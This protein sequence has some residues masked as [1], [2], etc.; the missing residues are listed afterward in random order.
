MSGAAVM[1]RHLLVFA[2]VLVISYGTAWAY[3]TPIMP[4]HKDYTPIYNNGFCGGSY[5]GACHD[6]NASTFLPETL[7]HV[8]NVDNKKDWTNFCLS[9][10]NVSGEAHER[11][12]GTPSTNTYSLGNRTTLVPGS[13]SGRSHSWNGVIG[14]AGTTF[15][16]NSGFEGTK[17]RVNCQVCHQGMSKRREQDL[18]WKSTTTSDQINYTINSYASTKQYLAKYIRVYRASTATSRPNNSRTK[19]NYLVDPSEYSYNPSSATITFNTAQVA[20]DNIYV[21]ITQPYLRASNAA[22]SACLDCHRD[23]TY[24]SVSHAPGDGSNNGHPVMT[25]YGHT[26]GL[27]DTLKGSADTN[28]YIESGQV[29]CTSCH[30]PHNA[31]SSDGQ[32]TR[33]ANSSDMCTDCHKTNGFDGYT[34]SL[35]FV[36]NHNGSKHSVA[37]ECLDCHTTHNSTN[38]MLI[39]DTINGKTINF[40]NFSGV[41]SFGNDTGSSVCEACHTATNY[42]KSDG[43]GTGH[44]TGKNC[45]ECHPHSSGFALVGGGCTGCHGMPPPPA[46]VGWADTTGDAHN[47]HM[48]HLNAAQFGFLTGTAA[49][50]QCHGNGTGTRGDHSFATDGSGKPS[51]GID[52]TTWTSWTGVGGNWGSVFFSYSTTT[53]MVST[54]DDACTNV[55]CHSGGGTRI[56]GGGTD[57]NGCHS[58]PVAGS[59]WT[60]SGHT[61]QYDGVTATHLPATGYNEKTDSYVAM[62]TDVT[63]CG[64]CHYNSLGTEANHKN[65]TVNL[66]AK[67][68]VA[69][70]P[71]TDFTI[72]RTTPGSN[73]TCSNVKCHTAN[74]TTPNWFS[75]SDS[76]DFIHRALYPRKR[77]W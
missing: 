69:C 13:Y 18:D 42:H 10:H 9:C 55:S 14:N 58:Y 45:T 36:A 50:N 49:C 23:R 63:R 53:G 68:N 71:A 48:T 76:K 21:D 12:A 62:T 25:G 40:R 7:G 4:P 44:N 32:L 47:S 59:N 34:G 39:K 28:I 56:W 1:L 27:H 16:N 38:I 29:M 19:K 64:K 41:Q 54:S 3:D 33:S 72:T 11:S 8:D 77:K 24:G 35:A 15:P 51:A 30:D 67:G 65:G 74:K 31:A 17:N 37:T 75:G 66:S 46:P 60:S 61:V 26:G 5:E 2:A 70:G 43:S 20:T 6:F 52:T 73:V 22:N 57:C